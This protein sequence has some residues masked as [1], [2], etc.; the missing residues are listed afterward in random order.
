MGALAGVAGLRFPKFSYRPHSG[1]L[2]S[3]LVFGNPLNS[4]AAGKNYQ[5][6]RCQKESSQLAKRW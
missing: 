2:S 6:V 4:L 1:L 5:E 3:K